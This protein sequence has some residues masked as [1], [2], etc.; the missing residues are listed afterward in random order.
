MKGLSTA[1]L[2]FLLISSTVLLGACSA[3]DDA[4]DQ[5]G[6]DGSAAK[7]FVSERLSLENYHDDEG[8]HMSL[9][10]QFARDWPFDVPVIKSGD[11]EAVIVNNC[12]EAIHAYEQGQMPV[13]LS[14]HQAYRQAVFLC[15]AADLVT[16]AA[17]NAGLRPMESL[18]VAEDWLDGLPAV[19]APGA[20]AR[21]LS[22]TA[23]A[24]AGQRRWTDVDA[25]VDMGEEEPGLVLVDTPEQ[26]QIINVLATG[27]LGGGSRDDLLV[28]TVASS[29]D[30]RPENMKLF[31]L[32]RSGAGKAYKVAREF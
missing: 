7:V 1:T 21:R 9:P 17:G 29:I 20:L 27:E 16:G 8:M 24:E 10:A 13:E 28:L 19:L 2:V 3:G 25:V 31:L 14:D 5:V 11:E 30:E 26:F 23:L 12:T 32:S 6:N 15:Y 18:A 22:E 4:G